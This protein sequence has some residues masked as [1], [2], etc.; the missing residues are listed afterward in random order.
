MEESGIPDTDLTTWALLRDAR[1]AR[2][3]FQ[4]WVIR[5]V[6]AVPRVIFTKEGK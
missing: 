1:G 5:F 6:Y 4:T 2:R 3:R